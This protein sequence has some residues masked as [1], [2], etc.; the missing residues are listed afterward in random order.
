MDRI[1]L[2]N[3]FDTYK[4]MLNSHE[5]EIFIDYYQNDLSYSEI[6]INNNVTRNAIYKTLKV[7]I[8][9][10][11]DYEAKMHDY[12]HKEAIIKCCNNNDINGILH[13][14]GE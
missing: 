8:N 4:N 7:V 14:L 11:N 10:L 9:K 5:Q 6:A 13:I 12:H 3:L 2:N 1:Y